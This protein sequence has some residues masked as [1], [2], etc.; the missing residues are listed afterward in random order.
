M[1]RL[2]R[3]RTVALASI[4]AAVAVALFG[5]FGLCGGQVLRAVVV[6]LT[7]SAP[8]L[9]FYAVRYY[10]GV[11]VAC[12]AM[13]IAAMWAYRVECVLPPTGGGAA[14]AF[15]AVGLYGAPIAFILGGAIGH[16]FRSK[17]AG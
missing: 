16:A 15:V 10:W 12:A 1:R 17:H 8:G 3:S 13:S 6:A 2:S 7:I 9:L 11:P 5:E 14:M 4:G